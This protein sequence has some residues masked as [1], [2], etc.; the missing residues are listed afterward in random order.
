L[1]V[2]SADWVVPV[3][4]LPIENGAVAIAEDGTIEAVGT[5]A[6]LG[7]GEHHAGCVIT[8]GFVNAHSHLEYAV[9]AGFG[10][11][12][13]F[14]PWIGTHI[15]RKDALDFDD[16][17]AIATVG[18]H[19]S[20]RSGVTTVG[21]CSF[22]GATA[23]A[24]ASSGLRAIVYLEVFNTDG[25]PLDRFD[26]ART[27]IEHVVSDRVR[28]GVSPHA[29]YTCTIEIYRACAELDIPQATHFAESAAERDWL[30]SGVG[31]WSPLARF[32]VPPPGET[33][34]RM[35]A[36]EGLLGPSLMAA[37]CVHADAEEIDLLARHGVGVAH[38]PRSNGYLGCGVAPVAELREAGVTVSIATDSP[39][40]TPSLD[41]FEEIRAAIVG[42]RARA[43]APGAL[44]A[45]EALE[46]AT[47]DG[48]RVLG[49]SD[50]IGSLVPGKLADLA[51]ISLVDSPFDPVEDPV[52]AVVLG[53]A[54]DR[55]AATLVAGEQRY[56][57]GTS[58][59]PDSTRAARRARSKMLP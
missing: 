24:A 8:P 21:D 59:W 4:G 58:R 47:L 17:T 51:V 37:H 34:I 56:V 5:I 49:L 22:S 2:I 31:D 11:G 3:E 50:Q 15:Q 48:A 43:G 6:D 14:V 39:A 36:A 16:M 44:T 32:L 54:P 28:I 30:V 26:E 45:A 27:R 7:K 57:K 20:L 1:N 42:A 38:C 53:G 25:N 19:E 13:P 23:L 12:L 55:V 40:S 46:L 52:I 35:L 29:P 33:G 10:D 9:Y 41:M 18:A